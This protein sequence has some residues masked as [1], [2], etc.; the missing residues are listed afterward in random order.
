VFVKLSHNELFTLEFASARLQLHFL[1][2]LLS[3]LASI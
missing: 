1:F 2:K 3:H